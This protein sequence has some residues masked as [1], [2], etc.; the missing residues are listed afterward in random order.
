MKTWLKINGVKNYS[1]HND[2]KYDFNSFNKYN[3]TY[4]KTTKMKP[5][6]FKSSDKDPKFKVNG[7]YSRKRLKFKLARKSFSY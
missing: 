5:T 2:G 3:N 6:D 7:I 4:H 1:L